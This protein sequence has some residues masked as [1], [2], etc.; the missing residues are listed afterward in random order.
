MLTDCGMGFF[1]II[2]ILLYIAVFIYAF[3]ST[4][5]LILDLML[6][7]NFENLLLTFIAVLVVL[8][9]GYPIVMVLA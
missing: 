3:L 5:E 2:F 7:F 8:A 6:H 1:T 9:L 4:I